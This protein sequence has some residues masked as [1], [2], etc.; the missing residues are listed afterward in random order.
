MGKRIKSFPKGKGYCNYTVI[1][2]EICKA[3]AVLRKRRTCEYNN[4][5]SKKQTKL[6][7]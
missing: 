1:M 2:W 3:F 7:M 5:F 6:Q 4:L